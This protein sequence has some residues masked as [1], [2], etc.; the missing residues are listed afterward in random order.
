MP[1]EN[2]SS[3]CV[4]R[5]HSTFGE[6]LRSKSLKVAYCGIGGGDATEQRKW[7]AN[8]DEYRSLVRQGIE[9]ETTSPTS[10][11]KAKAIS[12]ATGRAFQG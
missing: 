3:A 9:P 4:T 1:G 2:C 6:C 5:D 11:L 10:V 8:L 7:D 12:D